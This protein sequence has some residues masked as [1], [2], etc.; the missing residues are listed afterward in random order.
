MFFDMINRFGIT[1]VHFLLKQFKGK[2]YSY[3]E[4]FRFDTFNANISIVFLWQIALKLLKN[5]CHEIWQFAFKAQLYASGKKF[6][7]IG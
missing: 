1:A 3:E 5:T 6:K 4:G 2:F 7:I